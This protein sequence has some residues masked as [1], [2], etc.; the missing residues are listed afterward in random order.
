MGNINEYILSKRIRNF[1]AK[2]GI[3][4]L[5]TDRHGYLGLGNTGE[6]NASCNR[7]NMGITGY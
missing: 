1:T 5:I 3:Q 4:E 7:W 6:K 2:L